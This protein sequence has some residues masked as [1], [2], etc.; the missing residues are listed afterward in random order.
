MAVVGLRDF[1]N[2][3]RIDYCWCGINCHFPSEEKMQT[4]SKNRQNEI[5]CLQSLKELLTSRFGVDA[6]SNAPSGVMKYIFEAKPYDNANE[7]PDF[8]FDGGC[9]EHFQVS[10][11]KETKKY[12]SSFKNEESHND[13]KRKQYYQEWENKLNT[14]E[15]IPG[16]I[17]ISNYEDVYESFSYQDFLHSLEKNISKH[18]N[19]LGKSSFKNMIVV[20]LMEQQTSRLY[21]DDGPNHVKFYELHRDKNALSII[22]NNSRNINYLIYFAHD[23]VEIIDLSKIDK[24]LKES[25]AY[26]NVKGGRLTKHDTF[27]SINDIIKL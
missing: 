1:W 11:S 3:H 24:L 12:G 21:I 19:S 18:V 10:S 2:N 6:F 20:F 22:K 13:E 16:T 4:N 9:I 26:E 8:V 27:F 5:V 17:A 25:F 7:F 23:S 14:M 15:H